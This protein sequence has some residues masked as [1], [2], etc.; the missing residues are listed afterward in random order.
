MSAREVRVCSGTAC[1]SAGALDVHARLAA[2]VTAVGLPDEV[3]LTETGCMGPCA[4]GPVVHVLPDDV[5]YTE[6]R[7]ED[8]EE[9]VHEHLAGGRVVGRLLWAERLESPSRIPFFK[10]QR[11]NVLA[12]SGAIDP[13]RIDAGACGPC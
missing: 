2:A 11:K 8:A 5:L 12:N 9:I 10:H 4:R 13:G 7:P 1:R 3:V 6:V